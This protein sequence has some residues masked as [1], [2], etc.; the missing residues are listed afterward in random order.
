M[1]TILHH[2]RLVDANLD[3]A[4]G[5]IILDQG[6]IQA[7]GPNIPSEAEQAIDASG[8]IIVPGFIEVHTHG[9]GGFNLHTTDVTEIQ[10]YAHWVATT[11]V[12][13][14][15]IAVVGVPEVLPEAQIQVAVEAIEKGQDI[16]GAQPLGIHL[17]GPY[18]NVKRRGAHPPVWLR[19]PDE[20]ETEHI[21]QITHDHLRLIT[22]APELPGAEAM[23]RRLVEAGVRVSMGHTDSDYEQAQSAISYG[24]THV[25]HCFNAMRQLGHRAPGP[26]AAVA[27]AEQVQG[28]LIADGIHVHPAMMD[29]L[30]RLLG[31]QRTV[32]I[33]DAQAC[34]GTTGEQS[35]EFAGQQARL[36]DGAARLADGG[37]AGSALTMNQALRNI[38]QMT[39]VSLSEAV[40]MLTLNPARAIDLAHQKGR[41]HAGYDADILILDQSLQV[42]ATICKGQVV[43][44][45]PAWRERFQDL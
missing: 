33:T 15:L 16:H 42:Q 30:I 2:A 21:L 12:T 3:L 27:Q 13:G 35:F 43:F 39:R 31:P 38:L 17:E 34:A 36:I 5:Q 10:H 25:T 24:I 6:I 11:G 8:M 19:T 14:F 20:H 40:G 44:T 32:V 7:V 29:M 18:I 26:I 9:G 37:L 45:T 28:E 41:L 23:I 22:I 1:R 4:D